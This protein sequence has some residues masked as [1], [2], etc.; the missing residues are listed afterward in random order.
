MADPAWSYSHLQDTADDLG[1]DGQSYP[2]DR[3]EKATFE[4]RW[5]KISFGVG[6]L[7]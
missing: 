2:D 4:D 1:M 6:G 3:K 7:N 5:V